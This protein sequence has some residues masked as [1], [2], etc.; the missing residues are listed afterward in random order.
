MLDGLVGVNNAGLKRGGGR[1][2]R[3]GGIASMKTQGLEN[4]EAVEA[5]HPV[6]RTHP[7]TGRKAL[8]LNRSGT[9]CF[10]SVVTAGHLRMSLRLVPWEH[11]SF[12]QKQ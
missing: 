4:A 12:E 8:Y 6:A 10:Q 2:N 9:Y 11:R 5:L 1:L 3:Q 7:G